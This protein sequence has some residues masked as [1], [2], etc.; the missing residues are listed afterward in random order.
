MGCIIQRRSNRCHRS[1]VNLCFSLVLNFFQVNSEY[2]F[3]CS[4]QRLQIIVRNITIPSHQVTAIT[5]GG[6]NLDELFVTT[7]TKTFDLQIETPDAATEG[8]TATDQPLSGHLFKLTGL[9]SRGYP[10]AKLTCI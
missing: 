8:V 6:V 2:E 4:F 3:F 5:F 1:K 9:N 10:S 7:A